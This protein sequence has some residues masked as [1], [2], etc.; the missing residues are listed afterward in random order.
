MT[1]GIYM[2]L[3]FIQQKQYRKRHV[4]FT[5]EPL[6]DTDQHRFRTEYRLLLLACNHIVLD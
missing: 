3:P 2:L 1:F 4:A 5:R 6:M